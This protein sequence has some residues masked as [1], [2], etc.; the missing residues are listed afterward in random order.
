VFFFFYCGYTDA[1]M[2]DVSSPDLNLDAATVVHSSEEGAS[3]ELGGR[4]R[5]ELGE[6][7]RARGVSSGSRCLL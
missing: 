2:S 5:T 1:H 7:K 6:G 4:N 3:H